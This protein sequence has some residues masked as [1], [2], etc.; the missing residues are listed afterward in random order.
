MARYLDKSIVLQLMPF[1]IFAK[2][3]IPLPYNYH[4]HWHH[5]GE[6]YGGYFVSC[7]QNKF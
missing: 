2:P 6:E 5:H 3:H 1:A 7:R 4:W